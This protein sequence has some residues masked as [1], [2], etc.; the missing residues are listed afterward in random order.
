MH[1]CKI[2]FEKILP[3]SKD[4]LENIHILSCFGFLKITILRIEYR[5]KC[6]ESEKKLQSL[7]IQLQKKNKLRQCK[8]MPIL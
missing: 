4:I 8:E 3:T 2:I 1:F 6:K 7:N 5:L